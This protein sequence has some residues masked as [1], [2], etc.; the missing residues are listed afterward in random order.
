MGYL[1][2]KFAYLKVTFVYQWDRTTLNFT[3]CTPLAYLNDLLVYPNDT[4]VYLNDNSLSKC[5]E[6]LYYFESFIIMIQLLILM[7]P[8][9]TE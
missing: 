4:I 5:Y 1:K 8:S 3:H 9:A 2:V 7:L 6:K